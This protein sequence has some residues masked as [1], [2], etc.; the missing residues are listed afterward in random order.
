MSVKAMII[1]LDF[2]KKDFI[3]AIFILEVYERK[4]IVYFVFL[5]LIRNNLKR[6]TSNQPLFSYIL[7]DRMV[8][9]V[10]LKDDERLDYLLLKI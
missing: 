3:F 8:Y 1:L 6:L 2:I 5:F 4:A 10:N 9:V 7:V